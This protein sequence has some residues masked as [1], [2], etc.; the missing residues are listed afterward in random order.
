M[1]TLATNVARASLS[2]ARAPDVKD[3]DRRAYAMRQWLFNLV[4]PHMSKM[5]HVRWVS[6]GP[7]EAENYCYEHALKIVESL[8]ATDPTDS[9]R[10]RVGGGYG[11]EEDGSANCTTCHKTLLY[12]LTKYGIESELDNFESVRVSYR[13]LKRS[14]EMSYELGELVASSVYYVTSNKDPELRTR[15]RKLISRLERLQARAQAH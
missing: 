11:S 6:G 7:N 2:P 9:E 5:E 14:P 1:M 3:W 15:L 8:Q 4:G 12:S 10:Y 13:A